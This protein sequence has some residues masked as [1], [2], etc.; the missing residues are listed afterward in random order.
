MTPLHRT[1]VQRFIAALAALAAAGAA[2]AQDR[3]TLAEIAA[4]FQPA[5]AA[6]R[7]IESNGGWAPV[8]EGP[9]LGRGMRDARVRQIKQRLAASGEYRGSADA[10]LFDEALVEA[11]KNFQARH[12][13]PPSGYAGEETIAEM[14]VPVKARIA[15]LLRNAER[16]RRPPAEPGQRYLYVNIA[17]SQATL[18]ESGRTFHTTRVVAG[19]ADF[20]TPEL[21]SAI[22]YLEINPYWNVPQSIARRLIVP[23]IKKEP[24]YL[25]TNKY[26]L[27]TR[28][29][30]NTSAVNPAAVNWASVAPNNFRYFLRQ[31]PG[32]RN[33]LGRVVFRFPSK[34]NVFLHDTV[35]REL[36]DEDERF[37][38]SGCVRVESAFY[39]SLLLLRSQEEGSWTEQRLNAVIAE[40][41]LPVRINLKRPIPVH[42]RYF[43]A[44]MDAD[45]TVQFRRDV[46]R[47]DTP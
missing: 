35:N 16:A 45:G 9:T 18:V 1:A 40:N 4:G 30:D 10:F 29:G 41:E 15:Q 13:L 39:L 5:I 47:R 19:E 34:Y 3:S 11:V 7:E 42:I 36:F 12:G 20:P 31:K 33:V 14:N 38:S 27:L 8:D 6:Y 17:N 32:P 23:L 44:W 46:Y 25:G 28:M 22:T 21:S 37:Y 43:T 24:D 2:H 26:L